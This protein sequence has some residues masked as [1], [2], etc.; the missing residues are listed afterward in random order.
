MATEVKPL[1]YF[2]DLAA[3]RHSSRVIRPVADIGESAQLLVLPIILDFGS[4]SV[5][6]TSPSQSIIVQNVGYV[7]AIITAIVSSSAQFSVDTGI[8]D[9]IDVGDYA[10]VPVVFTPDSIADGVSATV[11][12]ALS[13]GVEYAVGL[14]GS[15]I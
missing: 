11:T 7:D 14:T 5:G 8:S 13:N 6:D 3:L 9:P 2:E 12:I 10:L 15:G 1:S 4:I